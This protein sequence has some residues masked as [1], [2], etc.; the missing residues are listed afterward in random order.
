MGRPRFVIDYEQ[1][2]KLGAIMCTQEEI[3]SILGCSVDTLQRDSEFSGIYKKALDNGK[4]SLRRK[5]FKLAE[6]NPTMAIWLGKQYLGQRDIQDV[7]TSVVEDDP[8]TQSIKEE[9]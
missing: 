4:M 7:R 3:A 8:I 6:K 5:Q 9:S 2:A 1:V